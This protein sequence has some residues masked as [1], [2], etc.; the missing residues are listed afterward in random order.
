MLKKL[1][2]WLAGCTAL[3]LSVVAAGFV[4]PL[5]TFSLYQPEVPEVLKNR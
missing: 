2:V 5:C 4:G 1:A 3:V